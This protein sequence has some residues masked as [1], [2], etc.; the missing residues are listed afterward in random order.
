M[1][2]KQQKDYL[3]MKEALERIKS[4]QSPSEL[5][6]NSERD[7]GLDYEEALEMAYENVLNEAKSGLK[8]VRGLKEE[9]K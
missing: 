6:R 3:Q 8:G 1:T 9:T 2:T 7:W 5:H 4:Y